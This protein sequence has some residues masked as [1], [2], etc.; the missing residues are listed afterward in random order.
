MILKVSLQN[1]CLYISFLDK[2][3]WNI[4]QCAREFV[5][6]FHIGGFWISRSFFENGYG[7]S[8]VILG[9]KILFFIPLKATSISLMYIHSPCPRKYLKILFIAGT[10]NFLSWKV[11]CIPYCFPWT[12]LILQ[13]DAVSRSWPNILHTARYLECASLSGIVWNCKQLVPVLMNLKH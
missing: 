12:L 1:L 11:A 8:S 9:G 2:G 7:P 4:Y 10:W 13:E 3:K 6:I 5:T